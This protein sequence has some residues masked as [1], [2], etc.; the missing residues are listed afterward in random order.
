MVGVGE[1]YIPA[2][3]LAIRLTEEI[4]DQGCTMLL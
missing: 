1:A 2:F 3:A 4:L